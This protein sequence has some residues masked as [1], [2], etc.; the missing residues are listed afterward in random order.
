MFMFYN[1]VGGM[2]KLISVQAFKRND[3]N[4]KQKK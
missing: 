4:F 3:D 1:Y 2:T